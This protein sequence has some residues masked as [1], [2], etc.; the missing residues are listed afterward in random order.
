MKALSIRQPY[1]WLI[2]NGHKDIENR[3]WAT[4]FRGRVLIHAG[5]T[6]PKRDYR[7]DAE[8]Y[9]DQYGGSYPARESM[10]GGIVGVATITGCVDRSDSKWFMGPYGF[11]LTDAKPLP[12][13]PCKG[14]LGFFNVPSDVAEKLRLLHTNGEVT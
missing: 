6:Y 13:V 7:D 12:F 11:T 9:P 2:V 1:A 10:I 8:D 3:D 14:M 5:L 4:N